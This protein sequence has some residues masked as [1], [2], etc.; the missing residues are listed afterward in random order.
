MEEE[1]NS[2][3]TSRLQD[4]HSTHTPNSAT[5]PDLNS[6]HVLPPPTHSDDEQ[7]TESVTMKVAFLAGCTVFSLMGGF[8]LVAMGMVSRRRAVLRE[9]PLEAHH[10]DPVRFASRALGWGSLYAISGIGVTALTARTIYRL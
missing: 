4:E 8:G 3:N 2:S 10:E 5:N 6:T 7:Y 1:K 9:S